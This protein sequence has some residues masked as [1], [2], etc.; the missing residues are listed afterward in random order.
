MLQ[1]LWLECV[2]VNVQFYFD[3]NH[4]RICYYHIVTILVAN[5]TFQGIFM[6]VYIHLWIFQPKVIHYRA[7]C[8]MH[9]DFVQ[10][11]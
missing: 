10:N 4:T 7:P 1:V 9:V 6:L 3:R 8:S 11:R 5:K 2:T